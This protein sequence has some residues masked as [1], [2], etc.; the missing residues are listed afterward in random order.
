MQKTEILGIDIGGGGVKAAI[1]D[2]HSGAWRMKDSDW[3]TM[4]KINRGEYP[5]GMDKDKLWFELEIDRAKP[6][7]SPK[8]IRGMIEEIVAHYEWE[9]VIGLGFPSIVQNGIVKSASN[10]HQEWLEIHLPTFLS[11]NLPNVSI[12]AINDTDSAGIG[13][14]SFG[15]GK[16]K[17]GVVLVLTVGTGIGS[18]LFIDGRL[19]PNTEFGHFYIKV[20]K[21]QYGKE[22]ELAEDFASSYARKQAGISWETWGAKRFKEYLRCIQRLLS[23]ESVIVGGGAS[24]EHRYSRYKPLLKDTEFK[25]LYA[26]KYKTDGRAKIEMEVIPA[27]LRNYAGLIGAAVGAKSLKNLESMTQEV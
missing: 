8:D 13:E 10:I 12:S 3:F 20:D 7:P 9:G 16:G 14:M 23:P 25:T 15:S 22:C 6:K 4:E 27:K 21:D 19:V 2:V 11:E 17:E 5:K 24:K 26:N 1:V 18:A